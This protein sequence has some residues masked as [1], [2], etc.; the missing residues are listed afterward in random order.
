M[1]SLSS[2]ISLPH[3]DE[4]VTIDYCEAPKLP[5]TPRPPDPRPRLSADPPNS[6]QPPSVCQLLPA[7]T[8]SPFH[9]LSHNSS[10]G[11]VKGR[12][13]SLTKQAA[14]CGPGAA[15]GAP[16]CPGTPALT[17][18]W[19]EGGGVL[20]PWCDVI[21][22]VAVTGQSSGAERDAQLFLGERTETKQDFL[23]VFTEV[24]C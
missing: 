16:A 19:C 5:Q 10:D 11:G 22:T 1:N 12:L 21:A 15:D 7:L 14:K 9:S 20:V 18:R 2:F 6:P 23:C 13:A 8:S 4:P 17:W 3:L 24:S